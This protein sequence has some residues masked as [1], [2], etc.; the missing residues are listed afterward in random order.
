MARRQDFDNNPITFAEIKGIL[1][2]GIL[3][4]SIIISWASL[5]T[6]IALLNQR[7][8]TNEA[9]ASALANRVDAIDDKLDATSSQVIKLTTII[10]SAQKKGEISMKVLPNIFINN[11]SEQPS[12]KIKALV[13]NYAAK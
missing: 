11:V 3:L 8:T 12:A 13:F 5:T 6:Q 7:A 2:F 4:A 1:P 9:T 10:D